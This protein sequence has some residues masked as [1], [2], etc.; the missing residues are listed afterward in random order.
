MDYLQLP[1]ENSASK[2]DAVRRINQNDDSEN[3]MWVV[4]H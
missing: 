4:T 2:K 3:C 1:C